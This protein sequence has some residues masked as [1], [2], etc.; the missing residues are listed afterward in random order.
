ML[1]VEGH[2]TVSRQ[3]PSSEHCETQYLS[4]PL[5]DERFAVEILKVQEI[6]PLTA[7]TPIPNTPAHIRGVINLRGII[8]PVFDLRLRFNLGRSSDSRFA[9]ILVVTIRERI[10]GLIADAVPKVLTVRTEEIA[11]V[12]EFGQRVDLSFVSGVLH[13]SQELVLLLDLEHLLAVE[14]GE[15][16]SSDVPV[17][18]A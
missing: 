11:P 6:R 2:G 15:L 17:S 9:I 10:V 7:I 8:V 18:A 1:S 12:P 4:F 16:E 13:R 3:D 14:L 5:G